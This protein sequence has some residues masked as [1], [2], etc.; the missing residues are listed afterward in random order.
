MDIFIDTLTDIIDS[1]YE[2]TREDWEQALDNA[3][4]RPGR[5]DYPVIGLAGA[6]RSG[7]DTVAQT[8][9]ADYGF[10]RLALA[11][12]VRAA[13]L[14]L[15]PM[16]ATGNHP[17]TADRYV[18]L[19]ELVEQLGWDA[20]KAQPEVRRTLQRM[21]TEAGWM[22]HGPNLWVDLVAAQITDPTVITDVR[23]PQEVNWLTSNGGRLWEIIRP[24]NDLAL[25]GDQAAHAS[26]NAELGEPAVTIV[27]DDTLEALHNTVISIMGGPA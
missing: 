20:A 6:A 11:D 22:I 15:D 21:G 19:S 12:G 1:A 14:A 26:E 5:F 10:T 8:L 3:F 2:A 7:K 16:V 27:N 24:N 23:F 18:R 9:V 13:A 4:G 25:T 17:E